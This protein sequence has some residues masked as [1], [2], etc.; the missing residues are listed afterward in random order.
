MAASFNVMPLFPLFGALLMPFTFFITY[1]WSVGLGHV[2]P[3]FPYISSTGAYPPESC[4]FSFMLDIIALLL[5]ATVWGRHKQVAD[6]YSQTLMPDKLQKIS[7]I[8]TFL[9]FCA[10]FGLFLVGNFQSSNIT[11]VHG[12][13][14]VLAFGLGTV[15]MWMQSWLSVY[16]SPRV[17]SHGV[18]VFR[19]VVSALATLFIITTIVFS[20]LYEVANEE[21]EVVYWTRQ[22]A[23]WKEDRNKWTYHIL[24]TSSEWLLA[25]TF[26]AMLLTLVPEFQRMSFHGVKMQYDR[27]RRQC[28]DTDIARST[29]ASVRSRNV[30]QETTTL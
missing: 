23:W 27:D 28:R 8:A 17:N 26:V 13:G 3:D 22:K 25:F 5:A 15:Y 29:E 19:F 4:F 9:G 30:N 10:A 18:K 21:K 24:A 12:I 14:A 7:R 20:L 2:E 16:L 1:A 11:T 6:H